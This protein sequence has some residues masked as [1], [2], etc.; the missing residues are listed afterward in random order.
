MVQA[1]SITLIRWWESYMVKIYCW[2]IY[3]TIYLFCSVFIKGS[4]FGQ[5]GLLIDVGEKF[6]CQNVAIV[7]GIMVLIVVLDLVVLLLLSKKV[8]SFGRAV[9]V[10]SRN[11]IL[12]LYVT[13]M[14][15]RSWRKSKTQI[16]RVGNL[17][18]SRERCGIAR[19]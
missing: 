19:G 9:F 3:P 10:L 1:A 2:V 5:I 13:E 16:G 14:G 8:Q 11:W 15:S 6:L 4:S 7:I 17:K 18:N 12:N